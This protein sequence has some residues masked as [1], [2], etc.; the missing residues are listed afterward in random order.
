MAGERPPI[1]DPF[2]PASPP[3]GE[4]R[5]AGLHT[6]V[7]EAVG[8]AVLQVTRGAASRWYQD[9]ARPADAV[10]PAPYRP[11]RRAQTRR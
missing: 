5:Y 3:G 7:G 10:R 11:A 8:A 2:G 1:D 4:V 9:V 6:A